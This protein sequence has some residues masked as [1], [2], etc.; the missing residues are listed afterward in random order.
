MAY[1]KRV[2]II[3]RRLRVQGAR[4]E[5]ELHTLAHRLAGDFKLAGFARYIDDQ[6][7]IEIEGAESKIHQFLAAFGAYIPSEVSVEIDGSDALALVGE[8]DFVCEGLTAK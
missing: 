2:N 1:A 7:H 8:E 4:V 5:A 3:R 6:L